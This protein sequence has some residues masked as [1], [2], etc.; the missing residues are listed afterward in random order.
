MGAHPSKPSRL[1]IYAFFD[2]DGIVDRYVSCFLDDLS[3]H[4]DRLV[5][6]CGSAL[7]P[8]GKQ[9][10]ASYA[11]DIVMRKNEGFD[12]A[13]YRD[14]LRFVGRQALEAFDEVVFCNDTIM[15]PI[16]PFSETFDK[17]DH[18]DVDFW[19]LTSCFE[20]HPTP[21]FPNEYGYLPEHIQTDFFA[22]RRP[23][24][25]SDAFHDFFDALP[26]FDSRESVFAH[27]ESRFTK[28]F[29]DMGYRWET[30]VDQTGLDALISDP[31]VGI[32][33]VMMLERRC[34][35]FKR[36]L[37]GD[38]FDKSTDTGL[39]CRAADVMRFLRAQTDY[40]TDMILEYAL[41]TQHACDLVQNLNLFYILGHEPA[42]SHAE[43]SKNTPRV[44]LLMHLYF[45][46][47]IEDSFRRAQ[48][49]PDGIDVFITTDTEQKA[50]SIRQAFAK[51]SFGKLEVRVI[52]NRGRDVAALLV[53]F[54]DVVPQYDVCCFVHD[55]KT[56]QAKPGLI[57][58][59]FADHCFGNTLASPE[60]CR[61]VIACF[62][63]E[64]R[65]G[66]LCPP[67]L[68]HSLWYSMPGN[69]WTGNFEC[70][71]QLAQ[72]LHLSVPMSPDKSPVAPLGS[73][74]WFR[75]AAMKPLFDRD[76]Q[77]TDFPSEPLPDNGALNHAIERIHP[78]VVQQSGYYPAYVMDQR[79]AQARLACQEYYLNRLN[80]IFFENNVTNYSFFAE[81]CRTLEERL[82]E[83]NELVEPMPQQQ[84][85]GLRAVAKRVLPSRLYRAAA[86]LRRKLIRGT[87]KDR[88]KKQ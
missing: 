62:D 52:P 80:R 79:L 88:S 82:R 55:K 38:D 24:L 28:H 49:M 63:A 51:G 27:F 16:Y 2:K 84:S 18:R 53:G 60:F 47:L 23:M 66:L 40:D 41:R 39:G 32:P 15:G 33:C 50:A 48:N 22:V 58:Q 45:A 87:N 65:L 69:E 36:R 77:F 20:E 25:C 67:T 13:A 75:S 78:F 11:S 74:F 86:K 19:G 17:M 57:G 42:P 34:P 83:Q 30:F 12:V 10:L 21:S 44:C 46:D 6:V 8:D 3:K 26:A 5:V 61:D 4:L 56:G 1:G 14:G 72:R 73:M 81:V 85:S 59:S 7:A 54:K 31:L 37:F 29:A 35:V 76:W 71:E 68:N 9:R 70:A 43:H 64:P